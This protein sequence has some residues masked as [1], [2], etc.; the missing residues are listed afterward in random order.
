MPAPEVKI[1]DTV[2]FTLENGDMVPAPDGN[3]GT[4]PARTAAIVTGV[5]PDNDTVDLV[6][7]L[8]SS[9]APIAYGQYG[10]IYDKGGISYGA[11]P[12]EWQLPATDGAAPKPPEADKPSLPAGDKPGRG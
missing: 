3:P 12:G 6:I 1:G 2:S 10:R 8:H 5:H 11:Q 7:F 9:T 4:I